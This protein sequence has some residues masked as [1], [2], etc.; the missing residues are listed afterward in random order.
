MLAKDLLLCRDFVCVL[1]VKRND[2]TLDLFHKDYKLIKK[3]PPE[4]DDTRVVFWLRPENFGDIADQSVALYHALEQMYRSGG[5]CIYFDEAGY[6]AGHLRLAQPLG[7][8]MAGSPIAG[9]QRH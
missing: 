8:G 1:A 2:D 3:W 6:I 9:L 4:Y 7:V 5:W